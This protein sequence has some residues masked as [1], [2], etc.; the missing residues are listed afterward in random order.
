MPKQ[1]AQ[2]D[3]VRPDW[4]TVF[5]FV[6]RGDACSP[7]ERSHCSECSGVRE[8]RLRRKHGHRGAFIG[9]KW[10]GLIAPVEI[11]GVRANGLIGVL[12]CL[13]IGEETL[14]FLVEIGKLGMVKN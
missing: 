12:R 6:F 7:A 10:I 9:A 13:V 14:C 3:R 1:T 5:R 8:A 11:M 4:A 2:P